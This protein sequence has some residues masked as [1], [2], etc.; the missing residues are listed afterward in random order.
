[1]DICIYD[2]VVPT[3][4]FFFFLESAI[5]GN[6]YL[7]MLELFA[8]LQIVDIKSEMEAAVFFR[9]D[10]APFCFSRNM[11]RALNASFLNGWEEE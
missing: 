3:F 7:D 5:K 8:F 6:I 11:R 2:R 10:G 1:M 4:F 9:R